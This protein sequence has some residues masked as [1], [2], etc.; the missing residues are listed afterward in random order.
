M[1]GNPFK[2]I[3]PPEEFD[4]FERLRANVARLRAVRILVR[5]AETDPLVRERFLAALRRPE[6]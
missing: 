5:L 2:V 3:L 6:P 4:E 1:P